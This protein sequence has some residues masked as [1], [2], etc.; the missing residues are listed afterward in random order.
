[1][2]VYGVLHSLPLMLPCI[3]DLMGGGMSAGVWGGRM[4]G[5]CAQV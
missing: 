1:M 4:V 5:V 2:Q 3:H